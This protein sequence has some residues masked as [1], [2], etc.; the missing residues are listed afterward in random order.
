MVDNI[1]ERQRVRLKQTIVIQEWAAKHI[2]GVVAGSVEDK[3][4][5]FQKAVSK[6]RFPW[7]EFGFP[8]MVNEDDDYDDEDDTEYF[9]PKPPPPYREE[10]EDPSFDYILG[11]GNM[12]GAMRDNKGVGDMRLAVSKLAR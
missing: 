9:T 3:G 1:K 4:G 10:G 11:D 2:A 12:K 8:E 6:Q 7:K 5:K